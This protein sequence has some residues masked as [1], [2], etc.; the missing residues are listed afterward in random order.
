MPR[1]REKLVTIA[2]FKYASNAELAKLT[3]DEAGIRSVLMGETV[4][5]SFYHLA[6]NYIKLQVFER[7]TKQAVQL[8]DQK[9]KQGDA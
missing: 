8:L 1:K 3:L 6:D 2:E 9:V 5:C 7:D 4:A